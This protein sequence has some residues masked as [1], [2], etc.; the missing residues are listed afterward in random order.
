MPPKAQENEE[1]K[2]QTLDDKIETTLLES[3][4]I[5]FSDAVDNE[6]AKEA[7]RKLWYLELLE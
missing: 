7:I 2:L 4:R 3:R 5:F 6:T 1:K